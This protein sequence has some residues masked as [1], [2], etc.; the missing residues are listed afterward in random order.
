MITLLKGI[1]AIIEI[2]LGIIL[3][4]L[5]KEFISNVIIALIEGRLAGDP[6]NFIA[7]YI[8]QFGIDLSLSIKLFFA[9]Y[10][11]SHG[12]V[13]LYLVYA[14]IK[15][16]S[17]AYPISLVIFIGFL[18]YQT[19]DYFATSSLWMLVII[20]FDLLF[21]GLLFY[22]YNAHLK[23]YSFLGKLKLI[24]GAKVPKIVEI[25]ILT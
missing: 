14:I 24:A 20:L 25:K 19:Y 5:T 6:N 3:L 11:I 21:I 12:I 9:F 15:K 8:S 22:E 16:P 10:L 7:K 4:I 2:L 23:E 1:H 17:F 18:I 13:N